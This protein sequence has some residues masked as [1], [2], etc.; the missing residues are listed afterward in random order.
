M[1]MEA[2]NGFTLYYEARAH[3]GE[4]R[5]WL[6]RLR[7]IESFKRGGCLSIK[8]EVYVFILSAYFP[9]THGQGLRHAPP[10]EQPLTHFESCLPVQ[11]GF[12]PCK[13]GYSGG[14]L[15][16]RICIRI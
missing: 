12:L 14:I 5:F 3:A 7:E 13:G 8:L 9:L 11:L 2:N 15:C 10:T 16:T 4:A 6:T 1:K